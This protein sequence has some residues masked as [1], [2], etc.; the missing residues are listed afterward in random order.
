MARQTAP[1]LRG[2]VHKNDL[3]KGKLGRRR[4]RWTRVPGD[5]RG[6]LKTALIPRIRRFLATVHT[7]CHH[8]EL[9]R[10]LT[11]RVGSAEEAKEILQEAY[12]KLL[13]LDRAGSIRDMV[14]YLWR[15]AVNLAIDRGRRHALYQ[16]YCSALPIGD[17]Q[18]FSA[19]VIA[20]ARERLTIVE[21][22]IGDLPA[23]CRE[24]F[25]LH[26]QSGMTF[27]EVGREMGISDRMVKK[28]FARALRYL[29]ACLDAAEELPD[30]PGNG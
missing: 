25:I 13:V 29:R 28:H 12:V 14:A 15:I 19:E 23:R 22:A 18:E 16:R 7:R 30:Q 9:V 5:S 20:E 26:V 24:A 4:G 11:G 10:F 8:S 17:D 27:V 21:H 3:E 1:P 6:H 2:D